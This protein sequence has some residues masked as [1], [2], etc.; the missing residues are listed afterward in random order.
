VT[1]VN[2]ET[3]GTNS[4]PHRKSE[5]FERK[6]VMIHILFFV[7]EVSLL[8]SLT[9]KSGSNFVNMIQALP[10]IWENL[11]FQAWF[12]Q[13]SD[14]EILIIYNQF[15]V[16]QNLHQTCFG[17][18]AIS[19]WNLRNYKD[20]LIWQKYYKLGNKGSFIWWTLNIFIQWNQSSQSLC[21]YAAKN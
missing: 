20:I 4:D 3:R 13:H 5:I 14:L 10:A 18:I 11:I 2:G 8:I 12:S 7:R 15:S 21:Y 19:S 16:L 9:G 1:F 6:R 17:K